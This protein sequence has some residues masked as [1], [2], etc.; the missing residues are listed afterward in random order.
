MMWLKSCPKCRGDLV[1]DSDFYGH[2]VSCIRCGALL[3]KREQTVLE[4]ES[5]AEKQAVGRSRMS[6]RTNDE[7]R[8]A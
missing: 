2:Y 6:D 8:V 4:K 5:F 7:Q 3:D 1:L